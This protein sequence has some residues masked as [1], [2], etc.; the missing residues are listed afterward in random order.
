MLAFKLKV[1]RIRDIN[2]E[3]KGQTTSLHRHDDT[4]VMENRLDG[5]CKRLDHV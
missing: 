1:S 3:V 5:L 2:A 4:T